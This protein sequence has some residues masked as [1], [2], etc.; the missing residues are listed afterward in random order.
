M[1]GT[2]I[3]NQFFDFIFRVF[4]SYFPTF[5]PWSGSCDT[6][7]MEFARKLSTRSLYYT[8]GVRPDTLQ[9]AAVDLLENGAFLY[10]HFN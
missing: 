7:T 4:D 9:T 3:K 2:T 6:G 1:H 8:F 5:R 10:I